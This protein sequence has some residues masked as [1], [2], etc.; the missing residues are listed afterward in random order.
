M[1]R[2]GLILSVALFIV[3]IL[4]YILQG[5]TAPSAAQTEPLSKFDH[6]ILNSVRQR[7]DEGRQIFRFDTFGDESF[8]GETLKLHLAIEGANL[9]GVGPGLSPKAVLSLGLKVDADALPGNIVASLKG[10]KLDLDNPATTLA[11]L[12]LNAVVGLT[13]F[14]DNSGSLQQLVFS[15]PCVTRQSM[16]L[17][18]QVLVI[19]LMVGQTVT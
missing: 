9:G 12:K 13:G 14:F 4:A 8:W 16:I 5:L 1:K 18:P 10:G 11:L 6:V 3:F 19:G 2:Y 7:I 15:A 17:L